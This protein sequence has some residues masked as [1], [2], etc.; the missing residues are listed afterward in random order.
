MQALGK[1]TKSRYTADYTM[2]DAYKYYRKEY[3]PVVDYKKYREI[4]SEFN[5][6]IVSSVIAGKEFGFPFGLGYL[7]I[8]GKKNKSMPFFDKD[9]K[10]KVQHLT[11]DWKATAEYWEQH[12]E[13]RAQKKLIRIMNDHTNG[14]KYNIVWDRSCST[15]AN[16][17]AYSFIPTRTFCRSI[18]TFLKNPNTLI[19]YPTRNK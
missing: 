7:L 18:A 8:L 15:A 16:I 13:T 14:R 17:A 1:R 2:K 10:L 4:C 3:I 12:P 19:P 9:G 6:F 5:K 11:V